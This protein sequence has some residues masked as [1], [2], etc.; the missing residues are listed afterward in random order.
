M[1]NALKKLKLSF[2]SLSIYRNFLTDSTIST[3][4]STVEHISQEKYDLFTAINDYNSFCF[5][6]MNRNDNLDLKEYILGK[7]L[8]DDNAFSKSSEKN[9][10]PSLDLLL[11]NLTK[12]DL[13]NLQFI[14]EFSLP[15]IKQTLLNNSTIS[16]LEID[17]IKNLP[18]W[19]LF[20]ENKNSS[21]L[22]SKSFPEIKPVFSSKET[23]DCHIEVLSAFYHKNGRGLFAFNKA[24][25]WKQINQQMEL[26]A[27]ENPDPIM[28]KDL[29]GYEIERSEVINNTLQFLKGYPANNMLLYG[30]RGTGKS[31]TVK[32]V[33]N[34]YA[35]MGQI[36][37]AHV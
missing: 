37:R 1:K 16:P 20:S 22:L 15:I 17:F 12:N 31:S 18:D 3:L 25:I 27:V 21:T 7:I 23:W 32:A 13:K 30:D 9:P 6:L 34:E 5:Q 26:T 33:L 28:L 14:S 2:A 24:F 36:G 11:I 4:F 10:Y 35:G 29:I 8:Y 19:N